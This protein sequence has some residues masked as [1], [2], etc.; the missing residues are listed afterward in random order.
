MVERDK[1][2]VTEFGF[3]VGNVLREDVCMNVD[4]QHCGSGRGSSNRN[5]LAL[6]GLDV[7]IF[8]FSGRGLDHR[9]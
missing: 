5:F 7:I 2:A 1:S 8:S 6:F 9:L 3:P 4:L